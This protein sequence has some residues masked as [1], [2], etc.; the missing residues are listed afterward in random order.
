MEETWK[1]IPGYEGYKA[2]NMGRIKGP[3]RIL[4]GDTGNYGKTRYTLHVGEKR[5]RLMGH[6]LVAITFPEI[7]GK[8][9]D[10]CQVHH[11]DQNPSNNMANNLICLSKDE[12]NAIHRELGQKLGE[13]NPF[14]GKKHSIQTRMVIAKKTQKASYAIIPGWGRVM[15]LVFMY[16]L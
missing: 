9:F 11:I 8:W 3:K 6:V 4:T 13:K 10:G 12:H 7:C 1:D 2:S 16:R 5:I 15:L 14:F